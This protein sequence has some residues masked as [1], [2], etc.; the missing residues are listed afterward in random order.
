MVKTVYAALFAALLSLVCA[1]GAFAQVTVSAGFAPSAG[2]EDF[3]VGGN[4]SVDFLLPVSVPLSLG[5]EAGF[6]TDFVYGALV[7]ILLRAAYH[8]DIVPKLD[9]YLVGKAGIVMYIW[10]EGEGG[11][12]L[13][14]DAGDIGYGLDLGVA[15]YFNSKLGVFAEVGFDYYAGFARFLIIGVSGK[16]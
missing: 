7:P 3:G 14:G 2:N 16:F 5:G 9:L 1:A 15:Y 13:I 11:D 8:F 10:G 12:T 4:L 6:A